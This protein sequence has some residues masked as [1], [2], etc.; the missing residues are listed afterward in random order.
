MS[1]RLAA[2]LL[3]VASGTAHAGG[4]A[5]PN[6]GSATSGGMGGAFG[7]IADDAT[8]LEVNPA[9]CAFAPLGLLAVLEMVVAPRSYVPIEDDGTKGEAQ[10]ATAI[11]P[12]PIL[13]IL[14]QPAGPDLTIGVSLQNTFGGILSWDPIPGEGTGLPPAQIVESTDVIFELAVGG[15]YAI[16][17]RV[18]IGA[19]ARVGIGL[20]AV[21]ALQKPVDSD[22]SSN[23]VG[24]GASAGIT[25][26]ATDDLT[27]AISWRSQ[28]DV[29]T[30]GSGELVAGGVPQRVQV[31]HTQHWPQSFTLSGALR[32]GGG[33]LLLAAQLDYTGW[34]RFEALDIHFPG[35]E[36]ADQHFD[37]DWQDSIT[38]RAGGEYAV[39]EKVAVRGGLLFDGSAVPDRTIERQYLDAPK[40]GLATGASFVLSRRA[41]LDVALHAVGGP[42]RTVPDTAMDIPDWEAQQNIAPGEHSGS[43]LTLATG[44]RLA[45]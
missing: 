30:T 11:A 7:A 5:R 24:I 22:L 9:G 15:G 27:L 43:V 35:D 8:C 42:K 1:K 14:F 13:G 36:G 37:L 34:S 10:D 26:R 6:A 18:A 12:A 2:A 19:A 41:V 31:E 33:K 40:Y 17:D 3:I 23:G 21:K 16:N 45:L 28:L 38:V 29:N 20:F 4:L 39:S 44:I 32:P 25:V